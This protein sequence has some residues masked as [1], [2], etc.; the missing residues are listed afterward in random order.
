MNN[1]RIAYSLVDGSLLL[2][3][4]RETAARRPKPQDPC[5]ELK[6]NLDTQVNSLHQR[7][8]EELG[9]C[10]QTQGKN[11]DACRN[12]REQQKSELQ[13]AR[14]RRQTELESC[15]PRLSRGPDLDIRSQSC[16]SQSYR[17]NHHDRNP[18]DK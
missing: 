9:R 2:A 7:Q 12:L 6:A 11:S 8:D 17:H 1:A 3:I 15:K 4:P 14:D 16:V 13:Q 18:K 10:R 5:R